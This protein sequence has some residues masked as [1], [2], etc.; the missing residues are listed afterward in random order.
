M[1]ICSKCKVAFLDGDYHDCGEPVRV[2][3]P[4]SATSTLV[5]ALSG[6]ICGGLLLFRSDVVRRDRSR[7][8]LVGAVSV[9]LYARGTT[10]RWSNFGR[11][12]QTLRVTNDRCG[13]TT[14]SVSTWWRQFVAAAICSSL[15]WHSRRGLTH[16][17]D[18]SSGGRSVATN[19]AIWTPRSV[20]TRKVPGEVKAA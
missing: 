10:Y 2:G 6:A 20:W 7:A 13:S 11:I 8:S 15:A 19:L 16:A 3:A 17:Q 18:G 4:L 1:P 12:H 14:F 9:T 5:G